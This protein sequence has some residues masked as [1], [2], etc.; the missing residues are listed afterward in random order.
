MKLIVLVLLLMYNL[1]HSQVLVYQRLSYEELM[2]L[3]F[4]PGSCYEIDRIVNFLEYQ[5]EARGTLNVAPEFL[6]NDDRLYNLRVRALIWG[7]RVG[8]SDPNRY[9]K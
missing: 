8:C 1:A 2:Q 5:Q 4:T 6:N 7:V 3:S 9:K